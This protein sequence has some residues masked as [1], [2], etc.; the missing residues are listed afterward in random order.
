[1]GQKVSDSWY[2][3]IKKYNFD[4][5]NQLEDDETREFTQMVWKK[6]TKM[7]CGIGIGPSNSQFY[8]VVRYSPKGNVAGAFEANVP[9]KEEI[10]HLILRRIRRPNK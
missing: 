3:E 2:E 7:G 1:L 4:R 9:K 10:R 8:V 6:S 5:P